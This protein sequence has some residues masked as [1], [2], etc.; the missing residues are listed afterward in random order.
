MI[1]NKSKADYRRQKL[2]PA[3]STCQRLGSNWLNL[4]SSFKNYVVIF[5][6]RLKSR[7]LAQA[8]SLPSQMG[9]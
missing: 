4:K 7:P 6:R 1:W 5:I 8:Q 9:E 3:G 2:S